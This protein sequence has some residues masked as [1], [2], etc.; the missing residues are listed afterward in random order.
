MEGQRVWP[1]MIRTGIIDG[2]DPVINKIALDELVEKELKREKSIDS[3]TTSQM[4]EKLAMSI[5]HLK[6]EPENEAIKQE[7]REIE[8]KLVSEEG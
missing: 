2:K 3:L 6:A 7:I 4:K 5:K 8:M 1:K